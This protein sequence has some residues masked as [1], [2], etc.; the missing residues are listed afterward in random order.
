MEVA[1][2]A[3]E[4]GGRTVAEMVQ[5]ATCEA[6]SSDGNEWEWRGYF[7]G[8]FGGEGEDC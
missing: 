8:H 4:E 6:Q 7:G 5:G 3:G 1:P 2:G